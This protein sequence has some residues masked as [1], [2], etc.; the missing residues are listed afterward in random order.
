MLRIL[1]TACVAGAVLLMSVPHAGAQFNLPGFPGSPSEPGAKSSPRDGV[2]ADRA[3]PKAGK[4][5]TQRPFA[6]CETC[7]R[8][9]PG[10]CFMEGAGVGGCICY[11][12]H[13]RKGP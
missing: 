8:L 12:D 11:Y 10:V 13:L 5:A 6:S 9:C 4:S 1:L 7:N 3:K 2:K